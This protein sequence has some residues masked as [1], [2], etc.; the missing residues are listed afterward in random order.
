ME[1]IVSWGSDFGWIYLNET[2]KVMFAKYKLELYVFLFYQE[3]CQEK[4]I[5][6]MIFIRMI[7]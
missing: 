5:A 2:I 1:D 6:T 7:R 3:Y 4:R